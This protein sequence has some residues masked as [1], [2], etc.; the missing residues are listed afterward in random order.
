[1]KRSSSQL[2]NHFAYSKTNA[3]GIA[4]NAINGSTND[5]SASFVVQNNTGGMQNESMN[6]DPVM[7]PNSQVLQF[8]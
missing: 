4:E 1:M 8:H 7:T 6:S 5:K 3:G 2:Q